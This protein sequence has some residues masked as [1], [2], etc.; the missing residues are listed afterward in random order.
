MDRIAK[1]R[2]EKYRNSRLTAKAATILARTGALDF[3]PMAL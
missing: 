1:I 3:I 2:H